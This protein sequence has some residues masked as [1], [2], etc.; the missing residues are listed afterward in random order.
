MKHSLFRHDFCPFYNELSESYFKKLQTMPRLRFYIAVVMGLLA[1]YTSYS[2]KPVECTTPPAGYTLGSSFDMS[3][4]VICINFGKTLTVTHSGGPN[5]TSDL[6]FVFNFKNASQL[7]NPTKP[8]ATGKIDLDLSPYG[9]GEYWIAQTGTAADGKKYLTCRSVTVVPEV[10]PKITVERCVD[11]VVRV[12]IP[13]DANNFY[14]NYRISWNDGTPSSVVNGPTPTKSP[15][16]K[17]LTP[18]VGGKL[19]IQGTFNANGA[20]CVSNYYNYDII[21]GSGP[22]ISLVQSISGGAS[23]KLEFKDFEKDKAYQVEYRKQGETSWVTWGNEF[24]NGN[25]QI[26]NMDAKTSY[27]FRI[28]ATDPCGNPVLSDEACSIKLE[29]KVTAKATVKLDWNHPINAGITRYDITR[30]TV[31]G[32]SPAVTFF[33]TPSGNNTHTDI[34]GN[35]LKCGFKYIYSVSTTYGSSPKNV[36][37]ISADIEAD[38]AQPSTL[39]RPNIIGTA[40][41]IDQNSKIQVNIVDFNPIASPI[42]NFYRSENDANF[43]KVSTETKNVFLDKDVKPSDSKYCYKVQYG[44]DCNNLSEFSVPFCSILLKSSE[45]G[46]LKWTDYIDEAS[47]KQYVSYNIVELDEKGNPVKTIEFNLEDTKKDI[48]YSKLDGNKQERFFYISGRYGP[49]QVFGG[50]FQNSN[51][52]RIVLPSKLYIPTA[53]TPNGDGQSDAFEIKNVFVEEYTVTMY[54]RWGKPFYEAQNQG[55][56]GNDQDELTPMPPGYYAFKITGKDQVGQKVSRT[57][58]VLLIR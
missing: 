55:W 33:P 32:A 51:S 29:T 42:Y 6:G 18:P 39:P 14:N 16:H 11:N 19:S 5:L 25:A 37:I 26:N 50:L 8:D 2:Q 43:T 9:F 23:A 56:S 4:N 21:P 46:N 20:N 15:D 28:K 47:L 41:V 40:S 17:Y 13:V 52:I 27:C 10:Q 7:A 35:G 45:Q 30:Q 53:F 57:G 58:S 12:Q 49:P 36:K 31:G 34:E 22:Y 48:D 24:K 3:R 44:D 1:S 38:L 54:D